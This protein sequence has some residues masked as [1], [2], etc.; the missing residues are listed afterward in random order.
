M[1]FHCNGSI[2]IQYTYVLNV[3]F[4]TGI[5]AFIFSPMSL[6]GLIL[7]FFLIWPIF[8]P[9]SKLMSSSAKASFFVLLFS[10]SCVLVAIFSILRLIFC[11]SISVFWTILSASDL[12][13]SP[14]FLKAVLK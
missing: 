10:F 8:F 1:Y 3:S 5:L 13:S 2:D 12:L 9:V 7:L 4:Y 11:P 6:S 14:I